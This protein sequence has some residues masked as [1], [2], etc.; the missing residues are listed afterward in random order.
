MT[1]YGTNFI[2]DPKRAKPM[3]ISKIPAITVAI[4]RSA[5]PNCWMMP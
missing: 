3:I 5:S 4:I 2:T 1:G